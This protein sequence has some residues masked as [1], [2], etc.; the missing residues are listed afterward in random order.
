VRINF[1]AYNKKMLAQESSRD[2]AGDD[3]EN[4]YDIAM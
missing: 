2:K 1:I 4:N 3:S